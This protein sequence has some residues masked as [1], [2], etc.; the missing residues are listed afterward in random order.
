MGGLVC[1]FTRALPLAALQPG[2]HGQG[3]PAIRMQRGVW[4][5][6]NITLRY[7]EHSGSSKGAREF[8]NSFL[9]QFT[10]ANPQLTFDAVPRPGKHPY[11]LASYVKGGTKQ[12][13]IKNEGPD[14]IGR[15]VQSLRDQSGRKLVKHN[16]H[17][18]LNGP[19]SSQGH[20]TPK[21][22]Q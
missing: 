12:I 17:A 14:S 3:L 2:C 10:S 8:V 19:T 1:S 18:L 16:Q 22:P 15:I 6:T 13:G 7:C 21:G 9:P 11:L 4:Q 5:C 20:W